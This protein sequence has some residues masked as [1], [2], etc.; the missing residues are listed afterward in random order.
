MNGKCVLCG[1][2]FSKLFRRGKR[3][4]CKRCRKALK[5]AAMLLRELLEVEE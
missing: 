3:S 1:T 2:T 5:A 4:R